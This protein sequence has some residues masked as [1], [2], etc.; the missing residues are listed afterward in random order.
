VP[1]I[2]WQQLF[3]D[4]CAAVAALAVGGVRL[5]DPVDAL[6]FE[7][8]T[9]VEPRAEGL[10]RVWRDGAAFDLA[11]DGT[12]T[13]VG[14]E[15]LEAELRR[16]GGSAWIDRIGFDVADGCVRKIWVRGEGARSAPP[17]SRSRRCC[18]S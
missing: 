6:P 2:A 17:S 10:R 18:S 8:L 1:S 4:P 3:A 12:E 15:R 7:R 14:R 5:G 9:V 11:P 13:P 16:D